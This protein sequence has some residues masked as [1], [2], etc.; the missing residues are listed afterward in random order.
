VLTRSKQK[1]VACVC[2][3]LQTQISQT[4]ITRNRYHITVNIKYL[5]R[6]RVNMECTNMEDAFQKRRR[7]CRQ[8]DTHLQ[9][10]RRYQDIPLDLCMLWCV[11]SFLAGPSRFPPFSSFSH[12]QRHGEGTHNEA[13]DD[14][15]T[16]DKYEDERYADAPLTG[17][18]WWST[19]LFGLEHESVRTSMHISHTK[20][21][22]ARQAAG[23]ARRIYVG[24]CAIRLN[25][26][27]A[28]HTC[29]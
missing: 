13:C 19:C 11:P 18:T 15:C 6:A 23:H 21:N 2:L 5:H 1:G 28:T 29:T 16:D 22:R 9:I 14:A 17:P 26:I 4:H 8:R 7:I 20:I 12:I 25:P 27:I 3:L 10:E 24:Q